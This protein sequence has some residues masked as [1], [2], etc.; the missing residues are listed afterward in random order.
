MA[1]LTKEALAALSAR[2]LKDLGKLHKV[3]GYGRLRK[4]ALIEALLEGSGASE[5]PAAAPAAPALTPSLAPAPSGP[6]ASPMARTHHE[7][8]AAEA[9]FAVTRPVEQLRQD[10]GLGD[11]PA[12]YGA[13]I[14]T[15]LPVNPTRA[16]AYWD[17][18][19]G[20]LGQHYQGLADARP[21]LRLSQA[22]GAGGFRLAAEHA[23]DLGAHSSYFEVAP[24]HTYAAELGLTGSKGYRR[25]VGSNVLSVPPNGPSTGDE[26]TFATLP[27]DAPLPAAVG[28]AKGVSGGKV[29]SR[30][31]YERLFGVAVPGSSPTSY[32]AYRRRS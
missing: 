23:I 32:E 7:M 2:E 3:K 9:R 28:R 21:V 22:D 24:G 6:E 31:E 26:A 27:F 25:I 1:S 20:A 16:Y 11:L 10:E 14:L 30:E 17:L 18:D 12:S 4:E 13:T 19:Y 8:R 29:L 15:L 5:A